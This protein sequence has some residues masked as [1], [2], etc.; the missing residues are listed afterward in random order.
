M[1]LYSAISS[2]KLKTWIIMIFFVVFITTLVYVMSK[3][4]GLG[5]LSMAGLA[6]IIA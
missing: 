3:A 5:S 6:L 4:L 1:K 2:N